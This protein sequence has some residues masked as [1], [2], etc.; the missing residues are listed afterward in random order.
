MSSTDKKLVLAITACPTGVAH[1]FLAAE[2]LTQTGPKLG[3]DIK[4]ETHGSEGIRNDFTAEEIAR[5]EVI[6]LAVDVTVD[7]S[8]F[9]GKKVYQCRVAKAIK[10]PEGVIE[11]A[12]KEGKQQAGEFNTK[13]DKNSGQKM[14]VMKHLMAGVSYMVPIIILGGIFLAVALGLSKAIYGP[15]YDPGSDNKNF[16]YYLLKIGEASFTL[17]IPILGA[18]IANSIAG[19]AAIAPALVVSYLGNSP[20]A[21]FPLPGINE[22]TTPT[23]FVGAIAAGLAIGYTVKWI[24][25][26][27]VPKSLRPVMPIFFIPLVVGFVYSMIM[28]FVIGSTIGWVMGKFQ[29]WIESTWGNTDNAGNIAIGLGF[30]IL[31]GAMAGF[32][33]GGP[34]NKIA[35]LAC[36]GL[37]GSKIYTPMGAMATAIPVAPLGMGIATW[38]FRPFYNEEQKTMGTTAFFM[39]CIGISEGA[40]PFAVNDPKRVVASNVVGSAIAGGL[41]GVTGI[42]DLA[43]HGGPI[44]GLLGALGRGNGDAGQYGWG[45]GWQWTLLAFLFMAVGALI[46]AF[47]YGFWQVIDK[48][49]KGETISMKQFIIKT[50]DEKVK[51]DKAAKADKVNKDAKKVKLNKKEK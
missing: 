42:A 13:T 17:M 23:G 46:T 40:I 41:A 33:M 44:V 45:Q 1:T 25:T 43:G 11:A 38:V 30:G 36:T 14:G 22:V 20:Q 47:M 7:T 48:K 32:D 34:I 6:I 8:R 24:N 28:M 39:G 21:F 18:F 12:L 26:W 5:A 10:D 16:F 27:N 4:V 3:Y 51:A 31:I 2:K 49:R 37:I 35:F 29:G 50:R 9:N 15:S 19:R